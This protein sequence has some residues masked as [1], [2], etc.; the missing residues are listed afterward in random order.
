MSLSHKGTDDLFASQSQEK[1]EV[2]FAKRHVDK[3]LLYTIL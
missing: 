3:A 2:G 1:Q